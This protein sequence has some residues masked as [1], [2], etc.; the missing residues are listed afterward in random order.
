MALLLIFHP[1]LRKAWNAIYPTS[2]SSPTSSPTRALTPGQAEARKEQRL[3]FDY[4]FAFVFLV[5]LHGISAAKVLLILW[6]NYNLATVLPRQYVPV[7][8]WVFNIGTLFANELASGY[9][10]VNVTSLLS[11]GSWEPIFHATVEGV[12]TAPA[13]V[14]WGS[15]LDGFGGIMPRWE[16]LFNITVLRLIS[17]NLD[18]YWS[19]GD[20]G[21]S[22][23]EVGYT[24]QMFGYILT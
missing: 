17:F 6:I 18:Y 9:H 10:L 14:Q 7:A 3:S 2:D 13:L 24:S 1:L 8:T 19:H 21:S 23:L 11:E 12:K 15:W 20:R 5:A 22:P 16:I 4:F